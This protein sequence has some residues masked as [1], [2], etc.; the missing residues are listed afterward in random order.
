MSAGSTEFDRSFH[1]REPG[2]RLSVLRCNS[3]GLSRP[4]L[5]FLHGSMAGSFTYQDVL[6]ALSQRHNIVAYDALGCGES[7]KPK[8]AEAYAT[9]ELVRD[10]T[11]IFDEYVGAE[12]KVV[13]VGH[14]YGVAQTARL[15]AHLKRENRA[16]QVL[17]VVLMGA[18]EHIPPGGPPIFN[19]PVCVL[20]ILQRSLTKA[21][22][23][24][25]LSP[26]ASAELRARCEAQC[27]ANSMDVCQ[28]FYTVST[29]ATDEEWK[30]VG[31]TCPV[32]LLHGIDDK[33]LPMGGAKDLHARLST[34]ASTAAHPPPSF[35]EI[36]DAAHQLCDERP[37]IVLQH[38]KAFLV[39]TCRIPP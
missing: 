20:S 4:W 36:S 8:E 15:V 7:S 13:I 21:F 30:D 10:A 26:R 22:L 16:G 19:L 33:V 39:D 37:D 34:H 23:D 12:A 38:V 6:P 3:A 1:E 32:L 17:G 9:A 18:A 11:A 24:G 2:R 35:V 14:S 25:A 28:A 27:M 31:M 5:F 29:W